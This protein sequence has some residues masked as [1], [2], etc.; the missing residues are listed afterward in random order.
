LA[1]IS[2]N[3]IDAIVSMD[4][5]LIINT[6]NKGA[7]KMFGYEKE[8]IIGKSIKT[9][10]PPEKIKDNELDQI[11]KLTLEKGFI[12]NFET[13]RLT[14]NGKE[15]YVAISITKLADENSHFIGFAVI[16]RDITYQKKAEKDL[17]TRFESMQNAYME[18]GRQ[19]RELDYLLE[20]LNIAIGDEQFPDIENY[21]VNAA[22]MLTKANAAT[23]R[24]YGEKDGF[25]HLIAASGVKPEWWGK[26]RSQ[27]VGTL[28]EKAYHMH[29]PLFV[30]ELQNN[31]HYTG[32]K[33]AQEHGF[34]CSLIVP[35]YVKTKYI[36]NLS[37]YSNNKNKLHLIDN[38]FIAI[39][40]KQASLALFTKSV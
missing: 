14:K 2:D 6:W 12:K 23:L 9:I 10:I 40:V 26:A 18:L 21:I 3:S 4:K 39:F 15:I 31:P 16:Y 25:L 28:A 5:N 22:I 17:Q 7:I 34:V 36:G 13:V 37:I 1:Y 11:I 35:L 20:T 29:K 24:L 8:E 30:D 38:S 32:Q 19:R 33:L 27:F